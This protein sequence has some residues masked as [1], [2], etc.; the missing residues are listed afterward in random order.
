[1]ME[2]V[3]A[4]I[5]YAMPSELGAS[6]FQLGVAAPPHPIPAQAVDHHAGSYLAKAALLLPV[7]MDLYTVDRDPEVAK[8][9][10]SLPRAMCVLLSLLILLTCG[11]MHVV[12]EVYSGSMRHEILE[13]ANEPW[14]LLLLKCPIRHWFATLRMPSHYRAQPWMA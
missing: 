1:M 10:F 4:L 11:A 5:E 14:L 12:F 6:P 9:R 2:E 8:S 7:A 13:T 3:R